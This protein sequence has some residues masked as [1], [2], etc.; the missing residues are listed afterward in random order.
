MFANVRVDSA[1]SSFSTSSSASSADWASRVR[2][3]RPGELPRRLA[4]RTSLVADRRLQQAKQCAPALH[5]LAKFVN[6]FRVGAALDL[7]ARRVLRRK[8]REPPRRAQHR[9]GLGDVG[10]VWAAYGYFAYRKTAVML[11]DQP[12]PPA[13]SVATYRLPVATGGRKSRFGAG[14]SSPVARQAHNLRV[15]GSKSCPRNQL[16]R[17]IQP[18]LGRAEAE[19]FCANSASESRIAG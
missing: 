2:V 13:V 8:C 3:K 17:T 1:R 5:C 9:W 10:W 19:L 18:R 4:Q 12:F 6:P 15:T 14:W 7:Q 11:K 16:S